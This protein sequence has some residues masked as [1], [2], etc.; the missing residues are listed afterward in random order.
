MI[1]KCEVAS[2][3]RTIESVEWEALLT[4]V[5]IRVRTMYTA[6]TTFQFIEYYFTQFIVFT[7]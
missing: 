7:I 6:L 3:S 2:S 5:V 4:T 1:G